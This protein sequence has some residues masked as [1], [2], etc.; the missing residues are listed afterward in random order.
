MCYCPVEEERR[1]ECAPVHLRRRSV[2][3]VK[4]WRRMRRRR[5][6]QGAAFLQ[7]RGRTQSAAVK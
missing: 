6:T 7:K 2:T 3:A 1:T 5:R 4:W